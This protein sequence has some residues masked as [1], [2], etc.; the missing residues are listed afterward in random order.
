L[1]KKYQTK[2]VLIVADGPIDLP[3]DKNGHAALQS[4]CTPNLDACAR[5]GGCHAVYPVIAR[6]N[7]ELAIPGKSI[8]LLEYTRRLV[9]AYS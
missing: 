8:V 2:I 3:P 1:A 9:T 4:A 5:N 7:P 6:Y